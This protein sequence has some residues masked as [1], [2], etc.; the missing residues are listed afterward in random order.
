MSLHTADRLLSALAGDHAYA[1]RAEDGSLRAVARRRN[2]SVEIG[3]YSAEAG[4]FLVEAGLARWRAA[5][6]R[7]RLVLTEEGRARA[8]LIDAGAGLEPARALQGAPIRE[9]GAIVEQAESPL[10]WLARRRG[11]D[12]AP[13]L[14]PEH[15]EAGERLRRDFETAHLRPRVTARWDGVPA[16]R[17]G[18]QGLHLSER[19]LAAR[20]RV[21]AALAAVGPDMSGLCLDVCCFLKGLELVE[22]ERGWPRRSARIVLDLALARLARHYGLDARPARSAPMRAWGAQDY[23]PALS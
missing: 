16:E 13:L 12:G 7:D 19:A 6:A 21:E 10:A 5:A 8:A 3:R 4:A 22:S 2:V 1:W 20:Q 17:G 15:L 18:P 9:E 14:A 11:R 23:R